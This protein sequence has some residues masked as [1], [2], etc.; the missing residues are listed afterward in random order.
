MSVFLR[1]HVGTHGEILDLQFFSLVKLTGVFILTKI[2]HNNRSHAKDYNRKAKL[3]SRRRFIGV[4]TFVG[5]VLLDLVY[6]QTLDM[7]PSGVLHEGQTYSEELYAV[8]AC[9]IAIRQHCLQHSAISGIACDPHK[10]VHFDVSGLPCP[11]MSTAN[12]NRKMRAGPT[13]SVYLTHGKSQRFH[14]ENP[15]I[16]PFH[17]ENP[18]WEKAH[19][20]QAY[21]H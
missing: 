3:Y 11:E 17:H 5:T 15:A 7:V 20:A 1:Q 9:D 12:H 18:C 10:P 14:H 2:Q 6:F 4:R 21:V 13:N 8:Q 16:C 19:P